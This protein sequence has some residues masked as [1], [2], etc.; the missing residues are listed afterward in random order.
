ML[1]RHD[2]IQVDIDQSESVGLLVLRR[3]PAAE[4]AEAA[5]A[6]GGSGAFKYWA[7]PHT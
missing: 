3:T 1:T 4:A 5:E 6:A 7:V 2:G